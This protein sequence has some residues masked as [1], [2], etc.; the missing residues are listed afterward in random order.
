MKKTL[1]IMAFGLF[2]IN[3]NAQDIVPPSTA[4]SNDSIQKV[5]I[6]KFEKEK[7]EKEALKTKEK[8]DKDAAKEKEKAE[9][10]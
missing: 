5:E 8:A 10:Q 2:A 3:A 6:E 1:T 7:A 9:K 4:R